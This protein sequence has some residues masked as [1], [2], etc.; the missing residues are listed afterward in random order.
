MAHRYGL[1]DPS[2]AELARIAEGWQPYRSWAA[3]LLRA[4]HDER[5]AR[6]RGTQSSGRTP[7][8]LVPRAPEVRVKATRWP[9]CSSR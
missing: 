7:E 5:T 1:A 3:V 9:S 4:A 8:A 6:S 2:P